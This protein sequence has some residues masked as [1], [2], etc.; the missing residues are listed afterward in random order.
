MR[1]NSSNKGT[2]FL[3][4]GLLMTPLGMPVAFAQEQAEPIIALEPAADKPDDKPAEEAPEQK[5]EANAEDRAVPSDMPE[6]ASDKTGEGMPDVMIGEG[7]ALPLI[8]TEKKEK[9]LPKVKS[10]FFSAEEM[11][12]VRK[13]VSVYTRILSGEGG[14]A[15]DF[16]KRL[17]GDED[18][19]KET[20]RYFVYPQFFLASLV[21]H[22]DNDWS[23]YLNNQKLTHAQPEG[24]QGIRIQSID[25]DKVT[26]EW[27]PSDMK[28]IEEVWTI[29]PNDEILVDLRQRKVVFTLRPNQTFSSY[30]MRVL[31]GKVMPMVIDMAPPKSEGGEDG[32]PSVEGKKKD[33]APTERDFLDRLLGVR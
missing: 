10:L 2:L 16:L 17:Q 9:E 22:S 1:L 8:D 15:L 5:P 23:V 33:S 7:G 30:V 4:I 26:V 31:E 24:T 29:K 25:K 11:A 14:D 28:K 27:N 18:A 13:A 19:P 3:L 12:S 21:Y 20:S 32:K 6:A